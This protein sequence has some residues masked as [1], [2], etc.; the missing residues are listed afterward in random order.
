VVIA[1]LIKQTD[2]AEQIGGL[3]NLEVN[4][5]EQ[6]IDDVFFALNAIHVQS[7]PVQSVA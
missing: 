3:N 2:V 6:K 4:V 1:P 7:V 5:F